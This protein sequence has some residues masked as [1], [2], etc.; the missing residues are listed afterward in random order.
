MQQRADRGKFTQ[1]LSA[2]RVTTE[3]TDAALQVLRSQP[4]SIRP[5]STAVSSRAAAKAARQPSAQQARL[6]AVHLTR[7][8]YEKAKRNQPAAPK[9]GAAMS[10]MSEGSA[11]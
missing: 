11:M 7:R 3:H 10:S 4:V 6:N 5:C 1:D 2:I 9:L 8:L